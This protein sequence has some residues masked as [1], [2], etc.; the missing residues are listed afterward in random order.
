MVFVGALLTPYIDW[1][2]WQNTRWGMSEQQVACRGA[3]HRGTRV[4][5]AKGKNI[6]G[7]IPTLRANHVAGDFAFDAHFYF[8]GPIAG[9]ALIKMEL[10]ARSKCSGLVGS[11]RLRYGTPSDESSSRVM[12]YWIW[13]TDRDQISVVLIGDPVRRDL[14]PPKLER[15]PG[16]STSF[17]GG[18]RNTI[19]LALILSSPVEIYLQSMRI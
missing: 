7:R 14:S 8:G 18:R 17:A 6:E 13:R 16:G 4:E 12:S 15:D 1:A 3:R 11:L 9:L 2:D 10:V 5:I 19:H